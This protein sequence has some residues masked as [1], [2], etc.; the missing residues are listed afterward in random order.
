MQ[1]RE[2]Y[3][4]SRHVHLCPL[5]NQTVLLDLRQDRYIAVGASQSEALADWVLGWPGA[6]ARD[7][8]SPSAP[9]SSN[10]AYRV[11]QLL[12]KM[13]S[14]GILTMD[15]DLG[16]N[17]SPIVLPRPQRTL[18][19]PDL[20][21]RPA[22]RANFLAKLA[23][24]VAT[25]TLDTRLRS[26][27]SMVRRVQGRKERYTRGGP[28]FDLAKAEDVVQK[29]VYLRPLFFQARNECLFDCRVL[30]ALLSYYR[31]FPQWVFGVMANPFGA[32]CWVQMDDLVVNDTPENVRRF[33]PIFA[34]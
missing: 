20:E 3:L 12:R 9:Q 31:L 14:A 34:I 29:F 16:K 28:H 24:A 27:Q 26:I 15:P 2:Q 22:V 23:L 7:A 19:R 6:V 17:A 5:D 30:M 25:A 18:V 32:H 33:R 21:I 13:L 1:E 10:R 11:K 4:L 8:D